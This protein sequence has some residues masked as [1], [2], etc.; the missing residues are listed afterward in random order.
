M[1]N[2]ISGDSPEIAPKTQKFLNSH[3][4]RFRDVINEILND[5]EPIDSATIK[6][7]GDYMSPIIWDIL[8]SQEEEDFASKCASVENGRY[9]L[10]REPIK[11]RW[12]NHL[13]W[14][15]TSRPH[16]IISLFIQ[17]TEAEASTTTTKSDPEFNLS[18]SRIYNSPDDFKVL[19]GVQLATPHSSDFKE[20]PH[21]I[22]NGRKHEFFTDGI[23]VD[24]ETRKFLK[25]MNLLLKQI[26]PLIV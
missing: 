14:E 24:E 9:A 25:E 22:T 20:Y 15:D 6:D 13:V 17:R 5:G 16:E 23:L 10:S 11:D 12:I 2:I 3:D 19:H 8:V 18:I 4:L 7:L 21:R 26:E 1:A